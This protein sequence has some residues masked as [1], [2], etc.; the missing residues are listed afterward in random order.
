[1][2]ANLAGTITFDAAAGEAN[3]AVISRQGPGEYFVGDLT[4]GAT[5]TL[6]PLSPCVNTATVPMLG[7]PPG[8]LCTLPTVTSLTE[9]LDDGNDTGVIGDVASGPVGTINGGTGADL[10][11]GGQ[12]DDTFNGGDGSDTVAYVGIAA[13]GITRTAGVTAMLP[14]F[15]SGA[16]T[17]GNGQTGE[18]DTIKNDVEGLGGGNGDDTLTGNDGPNTIAG[19]APVGTPLVDTT[20][21]GDDAIVG[22]GGDDIL[23]GGD[24]GSISGGLGSDTVVG[25]RSTAATTVIHGDGDNDTIVSGLGNDNIFGDAGSNTL[26]YASV[27]QSGLT[28]VDRGTTGATAAL[29]DAGTTATGG[30]TGGPE[31]DT[32]HDDIRTLVGSNGSDV[33]S[34]GDQADTL[35]GVA[36]T[37]TPG[38]APGPA[39]DDTLR[40]GAGSD[41]LLGAEGKDT[42]DGGPGIDIFL[43]GAG[44]DAVISRDEAAEG[45]V[46][47]DGF[48]TVTADA[49]DTPAPDCEKVD[50]P[51][52]TPPPVPDTTKPSL[53]ERPGVFIGRRINFVLSCPNELGGCAGRFSIKTKQKL[54]V[55]NQKPRRFVLGAV[56]FRLSDS[57]QERLRT[58]LRPV[59]RNLL[60]RYGSVKLF[61]VAKV[62]DS[63]GNIA[64][65]Y[66]RLRVKRR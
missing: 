34:G 18:S 22:N 29:P 65:R 28:V 60:R 9:N 4:P 35:V 16:A 54:R 50:L 64:Q 13:A 32:I 23:L 56:S 26:A 27:I 33:L 43:A 39:G 55:A 42:L 12:E 20:S 51:V 63:S 59:V 8:F 46:C 2:T 11:V 21:A 10:L 41:A 30:T 1:M 17:P 14:D 15:P 6:A 40:G 31:S 47:G 61:G 57:N 66:F 19:A 38:V 49:T 25:G 7:L 45:L 5:V 58:T 3:T 62:R 52:V 36:P 37:G 44:D 24:S 48:D 53:T